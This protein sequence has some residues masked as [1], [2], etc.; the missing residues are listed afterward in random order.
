MSIYKTAAF[1]KW[2]KK[3]SVGD[4]SLL[5]AIKEIEMGLVDANLGGGVFKKRVARK[6][7]GK[8]GSFRTI[9]AS[10]YKG[11]WIFIFGFAKNEK[12]NID[13]QE[14]LAIQEYAKFLMSLDAIQINQLIENQELYEVYHE[15]K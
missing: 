9:L 6:G 13:H 2:Q 7:F 1:N 14:L 3:V 11:R 12:A 4:N 10:N 5:T 8:S 15:T